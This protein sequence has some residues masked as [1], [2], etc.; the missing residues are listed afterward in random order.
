MDR[1]RGPAPSGKCKVFP[2]LIKK[3][4][5]RIRLD[6]EFQTANEAALILPC[7]LSHSN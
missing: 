6:D 2:N 1:P 3:A 7:V 5:G 4:H